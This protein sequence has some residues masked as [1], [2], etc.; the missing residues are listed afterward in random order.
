MGH[1]VVKGKKIEADGGK[2]N[3]SECYIEKISDIKGLQELQGLEELCLNHNEIYEIKG[4][5][6]LTN[7]KK[8]DL[9]GNWISEIQGLGAPIN[10]GILTS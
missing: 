10:R 2:L 6:K 8:L 4:L 3:L 7:L 5:D 9:H 1:L